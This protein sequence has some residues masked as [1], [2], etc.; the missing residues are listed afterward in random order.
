M[1]MI[2]INW[3][4]LSRTLCSWTAVK[5]FVVF[6]FRFFSWF[7]VPIENCSYVKSHHYRLRAAKFDL[8]GHWAVRVGF[9]NVPHLLWQGHPFIS[10]PRTLASTS[11]AERFTDFDAIH[12]ISELGIKWTKN[13]IIL[14][15]HIINTQI[16]RFSDGKA[17]R[18]TLKYTRINWAWL[19][20]YIAS[21]LD[22]HWESCY[23][24]YMCKFNYI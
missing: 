2:T 4:F 20:A 15:Q 13:V 24:S 5:S 1:K 21:R 6:F 14:Y 12:N 7:F 17:K 10:S 8:H 19:F 22:L 23:V 16:Y 3:I 18:S 9:F 11:V